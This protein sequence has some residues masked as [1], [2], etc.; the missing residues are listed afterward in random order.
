MHKWLI[1][2]KNSFITTSTPAELVVEGYLVGFEVLEPH[3]GKSIELD[4]GRNRVF[5]V[6]GRFHQKPS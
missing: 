6:L 2:I 3:C 5:P 4:R 1:I